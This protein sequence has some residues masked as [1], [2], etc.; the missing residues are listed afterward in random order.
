MAALLWKAATN[1]LNYCRSIEI[2][3][4][5][6]K[7]HVEWRLPQ[8][9]AIHLSKRERKEK[10]RA[11]CNWSPQFGISR[12]RRSELGLWLWGFFYYCCSLGREWQRKRKCL[13]IRRH[14]LP[15]AFWNTFNL[16]I[17]MYLFP[18]SEKREIVIASITL[19]LSSL[20]YRGDKSSL[21]ITPWYSVLLQH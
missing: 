2:Q 7:A 9:K 11:E 14:C 6:F 21:M 19:T 10:N 15:L 3:G 4:Y 1:T 16:K 13:Y 8:L 5:D 18:S 17:I 12:M 20:L